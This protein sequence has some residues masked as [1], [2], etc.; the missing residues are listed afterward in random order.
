M[1]RIKTITQP[2]HTHGT[3]NKRPPTNCGYPGGTGL[4]PEPYPCTR[5]SAGA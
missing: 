1:V 5:D 2:E 4:Y 3:V